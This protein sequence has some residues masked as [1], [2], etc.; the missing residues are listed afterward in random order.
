[1]EANSVPVVF[2]YIDPGT[3]SM[4]LA[5]LIGLVS[6]ISYSFRSFINKI[7]FLRKVDVDQERYPF[8][9][10]T[11][12]KRYW[13]VFEPICEEFEKNK[14]EIKY[15]TQ[16]EDDP[17]FDHD[18]KYVLPE[19]IGNDNRSFSKLNYLKADIL[20]STTPSLDVYQWKRSKDVKWYVHVPHAI[21]GV[22]MYR[23]YGIDYY[24]S[25][26]LNSDC[27][28][29]ETRELEHA[30]NLPEKEIRIVGLTYMDSMKNRYEKSKKVVNERPVVLLAPSWGP[31]SLLNLNGKELIDSLISTG[32]K[33]I[34]RP[35]PQS[36]VS[37]TEMINELRK[38]YHEIEWNTDVDN[39]DVM[40]RADIL[41]SDFS[42]IVFDYSII[43]NKPVICSNAEFDDSVYDCHWLKEDPWRIAV[44]SKITRE[45]KKEDFA[46]I[47]Q[48]I[49]ECLK[50]EDFAQKRNEVIE[51]S[52][53]CQGEAA[54]NIYAYMSTKLKELQA[55]SD[56]SI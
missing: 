37:E 43:F 47:K 34:I 2:A 46:N 30:R 5:I 6:V 33:I 48:V 56:E 24:D 12:S 11:D 7:R 19:Y 9:I 49:D 23:L 45:L 10:Y 35:H 42:G 31:S 36:F 39:F 15:L 1:M 17:V 26:L 32:Y 53:K 3:G 4:L 22:T 14:T 41:I 29:D 8:V 51:E 27:F 25:L 38:T 20:L 40:N 52:W 55:V 28:I 13:N 21:D 50:D 16:S 18:F 44:F 54:K